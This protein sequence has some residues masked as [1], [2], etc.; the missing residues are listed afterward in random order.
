[1]QFQHTAEEI[2]GWLKETDSENSTVAPS[3]VR[4]SETED[5]IFVVNNGTGGENENSKFVPSTVT[6]EEVQVKSRSERR[7]GFQ[8][9]KFRIDRKSHDSEFARDPGSK[10]ESNRIGNGNFEKHGATNKR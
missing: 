9:C 5:S 6:S 10:F 4:D 7:D 1:M 8:K 2:V 3:I